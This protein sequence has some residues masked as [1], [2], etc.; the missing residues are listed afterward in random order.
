MVH[1]NHFLT[2]I[3]IICSPFRYSRPN[4]GIRSQSSRVM[5]DGGL[6]PLRYTRKTRTEHQGLAMVAAGQSAAFKSANTGIFRAFPP[7]VI[8]N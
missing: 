3:H 7:K 8:T 5:L 4:S 6:S 1:F 2:A